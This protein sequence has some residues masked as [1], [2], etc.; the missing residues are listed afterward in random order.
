[1]CFH[2]FNQNAVRIFR[3]HKYYE[4]SMRTDARFIQNSRALGFHFFPGLMNII[5]FETD[6]MLTAL[7]IFL[8]KI[9]NW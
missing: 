4:R 2:Q 5:H 3:V 1:M 7:W 6:V 8:Q 9:Q